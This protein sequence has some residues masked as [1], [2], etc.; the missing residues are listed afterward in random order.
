MITGKYI[1]KLL[2]ERKQVILPGFGNLEVSESSGG[3]PVS[4][5]MIDPPGTRV[6]FDSGYS[7]DDGELA[8]VLAA[9]EELSSEEAGQRVLELV[10]SIKFAL[11]KGA[12]YAIPETGTFTRD[13]DGKVHFKV[14]S[15]W[16]IEPDQY[17]LESMDLLELEVL[18]AEEGDTSEVK[19]STEKP[20]TEKPE[21]KPNAEKAEVLPE[22]DKSIEKPE[23]KPAPAVPAPAAPAATTAPASRPITKL[24]E[25][26][27]PKRS[28]RPLSRWR[29]IWV[30][31]GV[32]IA[33]LI[34]LIFVPVDSFRN[35][36]SDNPVV[37]GTESNELQD[38]SGASSDI[39]EST[40]VA[41]EPKN[42]EDQPT[43]E[44]DSGPAE[45]PAETPAESQPLRTDNNFFIIAGS[46]KHLKNASDLQDQLL[47]RGYKA[48]VMVTENRMYRVSAA[49]FVTK[50]EAEKTLVGV[51]AEPGMEACWLL[52]N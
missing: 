26:Q 30:V 32:L 10:D 2:D 20:K 7:R 12:P 49:S 6:R 50:D 36:K 33:I 29:I 11:D 41:T 31:A 39:E 25:P 27:T 34:V 24:A 48:E 46:F 4:G 1:K 8:S 23:K 13:G 43:D 14:D 9:G 35:D 37:N 5:N 3:V 47:A 52:S 19:K 45:T 28:S 21:G 42:N 51:K 18:P 40:N 44:V 15:G 22:K 16:V 17:G 38:N